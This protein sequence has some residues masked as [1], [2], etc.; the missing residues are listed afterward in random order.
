[1]KRYYMTILL[2]IGICAEGKTT[3]PENTKSRL[4]IERQYNQ[5]NQDHDKTEE[6]I[7]LF[8]DFLQIAQKRREKLK[9]VIFNKDQIEDRL[10]VL[11]TNLTKIKD[12]LETGKIKYTSIEQL[13]TPYEDIINFIRKDIRRALYYNEY[14][15]NNGKSQYSAYIETLTLDKKSETSPNLEFLPVL[16]RYWSFRY[17]DKT[18]EIQKEEIIKLKSEI[19]ALDLSKMEALF[20]EYKTFQLGIIDF[21]SQKIKEKVQSLNDDNDKTEKQLVELESLLEDRQQVINTKLINAVYL[22][23]VALVVLF[24]GLYFFK[25]EIAGK[26]IEK[27][28]LVE[29]ISMAF[30]LITIIILG[31]GAKIGNETLGTLLG[32]IAGYIFGSRGVLRP[33]VN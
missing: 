5:L 29:V 9:E 16:N 6:E 15:Y 12:E 32:T 11:K 2:L 27:R 14:S 19:E 13:T 8:K 17:R 1:M 20:N 4:A 21:V 30:M 23:I 26:I 28:S 22:M 10:K 24:M 7:K 25:V 33:N 18:I 31:T 3:E